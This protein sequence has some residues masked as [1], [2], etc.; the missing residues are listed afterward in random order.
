MNGTTFDP[1]LSL[2]FAFLW[3]GSEVADDIHRAVGSGAKRTV[4]R[5]ALEEEF[6]LQDLA[7]ERGRAN[8]LAIE[9]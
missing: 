9:A 7:N 1:E 6:A 2:G 8:I 5:M 4:P 3:C